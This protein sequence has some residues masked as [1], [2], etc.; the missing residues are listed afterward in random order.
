MT[1]TQT[2]HH[3][4]HPLLPLPM[5]PKVLC[6]GTFSASLLPPTLTKMTTQMILGE[7]LGDADGTALREA[8]GKA[9]GMMKE[10]LTAKRSVMHS[11]DGDALGKALGVADGDALDAA[12]GEEMGVAT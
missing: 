6:L 5:E 4:Q 9:L 3:R 8:L 10:T 12:D 2:L 7:A 11:A 1:T